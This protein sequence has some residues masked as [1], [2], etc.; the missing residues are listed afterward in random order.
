MR[1]LTVA[2]VAFVYKD[3]ML[4]EGAVVVRGLYE[5]AA[6]DAAALARAR[7]GQVVPPG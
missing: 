7:G 1:W 4:E 2:A 6:D 3:N 5:D